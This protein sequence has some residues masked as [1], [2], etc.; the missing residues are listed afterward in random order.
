MIC[1][2]FITPEGNL[3]AL[4]SDFVDALAGEKEVQ[5]VTSVEYN[6]QSQ[7]WQTAIIVKPTDANPTPEFNAACKR[8]CDYIGSSFTIRPDFGIRGL[9]THR[10][11]FFQIIITSLIRSNILEAEK[12]IINF[13]L[14]EKIENN[15]MEISPT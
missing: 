11:F 12:K 6:K 13:V 3:E 10:G 15:S 8:L 1:S 14:Q 4:G 7:D 5:R 9:K 2:L